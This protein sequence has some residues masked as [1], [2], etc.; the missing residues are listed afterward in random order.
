[1]P[2]TIRVDVNTLARYNKGGSK[3]ATKLNIWLRSKGIKFD[4][5][6]RVD[7]SIRDL[8]NI[9][10]QLDVP[11]KEEI[12]EVD[13]N[14]YANGFEWFCKTFLDESPFVDKLNIEDLAKQMA[15][16]ARQHNNFYKGKAWTGTSFNGG[17]TMAS[18]FQYG[19]ITNIKSPYKKF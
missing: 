6:T 17:S 9:Y 7:Y 12:L 4:S 16:E 15:D 1:M 14:R 3:S 5:N 8:Y 18:P 2:L 11:G 13:H 10:T 19:N